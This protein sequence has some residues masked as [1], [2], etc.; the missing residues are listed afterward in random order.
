MSFLFK[1]QLS[2]RTVLKGAG[3]TIALPLLAR[4]KAVEVVIVS[5]EPGKSDEIA[6]ADIAQHLARHGLK[7]W[8]F[9]PSSWVIWGLEKC[10]LAWDV[11]EISPERQATKQIAG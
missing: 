7:V 4:A 3:A 9:D 2:R 10:G 6:G 11:V 1:K 5:G 8:Q